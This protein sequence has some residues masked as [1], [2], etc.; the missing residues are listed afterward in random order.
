M[1]VCRN[2]LWALENP[3]ESLRQWKRVLKPDGFL[4]YQDANHY[5]YLFDEQ[6]LEYRRR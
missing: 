1:V 3:E 4:I 5:Y 6:N 2:L